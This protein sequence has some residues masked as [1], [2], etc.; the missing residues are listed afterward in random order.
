M[1]ASSKRP[2]K[3]G[4]IAHSRHPQSRRLH[5]RLAAISFVLSLTVLCTA[6]P[7]AHAAGASKNQ[8]QHLINDGLDL[9]RAGKDTEALVKFEEAHRL[10][11]TPRSS[12]QLGLCLQALGR[13]S[14]ADVHLSD[15]LNAKADAWVLK[16]RTTLKDS[17]EQVKQN[18]GR[19]EVNGG[20]D[21][22][23]VAINGRNMGTYPLPGALLVNA[24]NVDIEVTKPGF[25]RVLRS[26]TIAGGR[27]ER[28]LIRLEESE[29]VFAPTPATLPISAAAPQTSEGSIVSTPV[30]DA[31]ES[32]PIYRKPWAW[33]ILGA[34]VVGGVVAIGLSTSGGGSTNPTPDDRRMFE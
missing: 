10:S 14:E 12:A 11:P 28:L 1:E 32:R 17:S 9:R 8:A 26:I 31:V 5:G 19:L 34:L 6:G 13:W 27:Y 33:V 18:I 25:K 29:K 23:V 3:K 30:P 4:A 20:P 7:Q 22:A 21:G 16:N 24:G 2:C 15:A